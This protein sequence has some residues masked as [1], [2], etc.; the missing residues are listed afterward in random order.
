[1]GI[2]HGYVSLP[3][4]TLIQLLCV[5]FFGGYHWNQWNLDEQLEAASDIFF[6]TGIC[7]IPFLE[8]AHFFVVFCVFS[9][10]FYLSFHEKTWGFWTKLRGL[11]QAWAKRPF[12]RMGLQGTGRLG[13]LDLLMVKMA[14]LTHQRSVGS[15]TLVKSCKPM[16]LVYIYN[17]S[18]AP[19]SP[20]VWLPKNAFGLDLFYMWVTHLEKPTV[21]EQHVGWRAE[22][23]H[24]DLALDVGLKEGP[25]CEDR[26]K[27]LAIQDIY[28]MPI[29]SV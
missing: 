27:L 4:G 7:S 29:T 1:M 8:L 13:K 19:L 5:Y 17:S 28:N 10:H 22:N 20:S 21:Q 2:F 15:G 14:A 3:E 11:G 12:S 25:L 24:Q 16:R 23:L 6:V 18:H 9:I 26:Q